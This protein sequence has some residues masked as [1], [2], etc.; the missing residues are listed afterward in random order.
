[1]NKSKKYLCIIDV[2]VDFEMYV[3]LKI[4]YFI[5]VF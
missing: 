2:G 5:F 3:Y 1:M 4:K